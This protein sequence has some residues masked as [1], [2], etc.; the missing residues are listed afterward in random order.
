MS[1]RVRDVP[2]INVAL[3]MIRSALLPALL[4]S[5]RLAVPI[6]KVTIK[7]PDTAAL[8]KKHAR[9]KAPRWND[10]SGLFGSH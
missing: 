8:K 6:R 10:Y 3:A 4:S 1:Q 9:E 5:E 2:P 7:T